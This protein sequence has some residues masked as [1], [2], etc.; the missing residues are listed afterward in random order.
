[1]DE[2]YQSRPGCGEDGAPAVVTRTLEALVR[3]GARRMLADALEEAVTAFLGRAKGARG[4]PF[5]GSRN[6]SQA[7]RA[8]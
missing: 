6:G 2:G 1:M 7:P 8:R 4:G 5:R 3:E